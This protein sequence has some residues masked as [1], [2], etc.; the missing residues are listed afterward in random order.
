MLSELSIKN[1]AIIDDLSLSLGTGMTVLSG[2]TGA[3][4]SILIDALGLLL[5][6][7]ADSDA[8]RDGQ[9]RAE[10]TAA[11]QLHDA[12]RARDWL[13]ARDLDESDDDSTAG[14]AGECI[15]RRVISREGRSR[16]WIN[17][18]PANAR[19]LA[20]LGAF[21][22][23][24]HGQ[25]EHQSLL[26][27]YAQREL[28]DDFGGHQSELA[29]VHDSYTQARDLQKRIAALEQL[30]DAGQ[31]RLDLLRYQ[32]NELQAL[33]L[34]ADELSELEAEHK[35]LTNAERLIND[36]QAALDLLYEGDD[37][38]AVNLLGNAERLLQTLAD[39]DPGFA[40]AAELT[41]SAAIQTREAADEIRHT[42]DRLELDPERLAVVEKRLA[43]IQDLARKHHRRPAELVEL[44]Q[45][46]GDELAELEGAEA[47]LGKLREQQQHALA[48]YQ[49]HAKQ[50]HEARRKTAKRLASE[51]TQVM[52]SLGMPQGQF[53]IN[54]ALDAQ[55][56]PNTLGADRIEFLVSAN[57]GQAARPLERVASGGELSRISL[58]IQVVA[59]ESTRIPTLV[60]DEVDAG[61]GGGVAEIVGRLLR[62]LGVDR[63]AL[64]VTHLPQVAA[65]AQA[66][67]RV[68]K[69]VNKGQTRTVITRLQEDER[70]QEL[71]R[72]LGGVELTEQTR[73]H[74]SE[75]LAQANV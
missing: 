5:G 70:V 74:A 14:D 13:R 31:S 32:A 58:A 6:D 63:Q 15:L 25:H 46:L 24:I 28:V 72:M 59:A 44:T 10:I 53:S 67:L 55:G 65:Q 61:I 3:G 35:R 4:K 56:A 27:R 51:A 42:L 43:N 11:F 26:K 17:G 9:Q 2:E 34:Q 68:A 8:V 62:R 36:G 50:L 29:N 64:C 30:D 69:S 66:H 21:L 23:D 38:A 12:E 7:R 22:V 41:T 39:I 60:F 47:S 73:A 52:Q 49:Q 37:N 45:S 16:N 33:N 71:A 40:Q 1:F 20:A 18:T 19:D 57:P 75:M 54:V 48:Q